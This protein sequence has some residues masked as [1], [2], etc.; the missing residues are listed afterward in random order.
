VGA[1]TYAMDYPSFLVDMN[2]KNKSKGW[3]VRIN[4]AYA[5]FGEYYFK[6]P[7]QKWF[8]GLQAGV[9]NYKISNDRTEGEESNY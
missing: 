6:E 9:Q 8:A 1:G 5:V 4:S 7:N 3:D 2:S